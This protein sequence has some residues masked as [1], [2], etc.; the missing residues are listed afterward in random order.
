MA[1]QSE[2]TKPLPTP[3]AETA[4]FWR[5]TKEHQL[6][7]QKCGDC[8]AY[9]FYPRLYCPKCASEAVQWSRVSGRATVYSYTVIHRAPSPGFKPDLPYVLAIV[10]L[11]EGVRMM[12]NIVGCKPEEVRIGLNVSVVFNDVTSEITLPKFQPC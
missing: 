8:G 10:D 9:R 7:I 1:E 5:G 2:Y 11:D 3:D 4:P 6:L 12:T